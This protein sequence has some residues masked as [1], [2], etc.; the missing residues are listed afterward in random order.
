MTISSLNNLP[1]G[2][3]KFMEISNE[4]FDL[5]NRL[6]ALGAFHKDFIFEELEIEQMA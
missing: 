6:N 3:Q 4:Q 1:N 5:M 2:E